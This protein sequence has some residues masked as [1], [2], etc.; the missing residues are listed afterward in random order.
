MKILTSLSI[1]TNIKFTHEKI[2]IKLQSS[3]ALEKTPLLYTLCFM[4]VAPSLNALCSN[5]DIN[6]SVPVTLSSFLCSIFVISSKSAN[7]YLLLS[8]MK[9]FCGFISR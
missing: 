8:Y 7:E 1:L 6:N 2:L 3:T 9:I 4:Y 5:G